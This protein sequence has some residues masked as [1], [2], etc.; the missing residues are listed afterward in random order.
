M[1]TT[2]VEPSLVTT[3]QSGDG[4]VWTFAINPSAAFNDGTPITSA[5]LKASYDRA[6]GI[7]SC[8]LFFW[9]AGQYDNFPEIEIVDDQTLTFTFG[10]PEAA[11]VPGWATTPVSVYS[12]ASVTENPQ[13]EGNVI[14]EFFAGNIGGGGPYV[15][16]SYE[17]NLRMELSANP[18]FYGAAPFENNVVVNW[19]DDPSALFLQASNGEADVTYE[20]SPEQVVE[21]Q[22]NDNVQVVV[23]P[24][25]QYWNINLTQTQPPMD[26]VKLREALVRAVPYEQILSEVA[27]GF[28]N[29]YYG[30]LAQ[31]L[32]HFNAD[33]SPAIEFDL[34]AAQAALDESGLPQPVELELVVQEGSG[35]P[36]RVATILQSIWGQIGINLTVNSL[37][38]TEYNEVV[39]AHTSQM[40]IRLDG[41]GAPDPGWLLGYDMICGSPFN[42]SDIC[43]PEADELLL[44]ARQSTDA[45]LRQANYDQ[46]TTIWRDLYPK[47]ILYGVNQPIV[48]SKRVK[49]FHWTLFPGFRSTAPTLSR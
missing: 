42:L 37:G 12:Q 38:P 46:I 45:D 35:V 25:S 2:A 17:P 36:E 13:E 21:L 34:E 4:T 27:Q 23:I 44:E 22:G 41:P 43:I 14:N 5:D 9:I 24:A 7:N 3:T 6:A 1:D 49:E 26:N 30:P 11:L 18:N 8:G 28:G 10:R 15:I 48:L 19:I 20:L 32:P 47:V 29:L 31:G 33:L 16:D 39:E 40:N